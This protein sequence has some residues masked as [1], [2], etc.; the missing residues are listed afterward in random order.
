MDKLGT[1][2]NVMALFVE[3]CTENGNKYKTI[4]ELVDSFYVK[5]PKAKSYVRHNY[6]SDM[7]K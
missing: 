2:A 3:Y 1:T 5:Y 7:F 4:P 6:Q